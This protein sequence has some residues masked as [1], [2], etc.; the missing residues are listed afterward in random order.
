MNIADPVEERKKCQEFM[1]KLS[2]LVIEYRTEVGTGLLIGGLE[3]VK[4]RLYHEA[5]ALTEKAMK[6]QQDE[7]SF[8]G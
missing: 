8:S 5:N 4:L 2:R 3:V 6:N 1:T 7:D